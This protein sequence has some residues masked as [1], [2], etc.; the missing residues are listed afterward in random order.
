M[1]K[2]GTGVDPHLGADRT[3]HRLPWT[4]KRGHW[5][6]WMSGGGI[7]EK[8]ARRSTEAIPQSDSHSQVRH[9]CHQSSATG[10]CPCCRQMLYLK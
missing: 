5:S 10:H 1:K 9:Y 4:A 3:R 7:I 8:R 6:V 2:S